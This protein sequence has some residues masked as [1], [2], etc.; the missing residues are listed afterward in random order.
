MYIKCS[1]K[2][3]NSD[4]MLCL[5]YPVEHSLSSSRNSILFASLSL[6]Y[7][8]SQK[9]KAA[10]SNGKNTNNN[11][12]HRIM[13][14]MACTVC[15]TRIICIIRSRLPFFLSHLLSLLGHM[16]SFSLSLSRRFTCV[17]RPHLSLASFPS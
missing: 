6:L 13:R 1:K 15:S 17:P 5:L 11:E 7:V 16:K 14:N 12:Q 8:K 2:I 3:S 4:C 9:R 10:R